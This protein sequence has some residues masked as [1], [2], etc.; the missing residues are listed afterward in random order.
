MPGDVVNEPPQA[1][2]AAAP[3]P[4][5]H[6]GDGPLGVDVGVAHVDDTALLRGLMDARL[7]AEHT[8]VGGYGQLNLNALAVGPNTPFTAT[9]NI[10]KLVL[11][12][13]HQ[14]TEDFHVYT[15]LEWEDAVACATCKGSAEVEQA[16]VQWDLV[17]NVG[18]GA[19]GLAS[20]T[21][22]LSLRAGLVLIP[23]GIINQWHEP[24]V[25]H[26]VDRPSVEEELIPSTWR[27]LGVGVVGQPVHGL[28]YEAY[29]T[30]TLDPLGLS[31]EGLQE[32]KGNASKQPTG[33]LQASARIELE[34]ML[35]MIVGASG[36][37]SDVGGSW[38][39]GTPFTDVNGKALLLK[40]PLF[41]LEGDARVRRAGFEARALMVGFWLPNAGDLM[42]ARSVDGSVL[43]PT[44]ASGEGAIATS[45][46]GLELEAAYDVL[47][48]F[49]STEQQLLPFVRT[50]FYDTN[51]TVPAG[52]KRDP[53]RNVKEWT[54]GLTYRPLQ[55]IVFK[56][57]FQLRNRK[58][59]LDEM[60][61]NLGIG[62]MF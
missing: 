22:A 32:A 11:F 52:F 53:S 42:A 36:I 45:M 3:A 37:A 60:Q 31:P 47:H 2:H 39:G 13:A 35:G 19:A 24:S 44:T 26:G 49:G 18:D 34:P 14:F 6:V 40:E 5:L 9:A 21:P 30:T 54:F 43:Y 17:H 10:E 61:A 56:G 28:R 4:L 58:L 16:F 12:V 33:S 7:R 23:I 15:E 25:F 48:P 1:S 29:V 38:L 57:D 50:S 41:A 8:V 59:G 20:T 62:F 46:V 51:F 27:E 55:Q